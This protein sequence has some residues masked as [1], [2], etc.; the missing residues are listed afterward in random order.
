MKK[1]VFGLCLFLSITACNKSD[2]LPSLG[3]KDN[4]K[5]FNG[6]NKDL[7]NSFSKLFD[8]VENL[9]CVTLVDKKKDYSVVNINLDKNSEQT[10]EALIDK[11]FTN[12]NSVQKDI[13]FTEIYKNEQSPYR[14][15]VDSISDMSQYSEEYKLEMEYFIK[16]IENGEIENV[17]K[18]ISDFNNKIYTSKSLSN[19]EKVQLIA[20]SALTNSFY[21]FVKEGGLEKVQSSIMQEIYTSNNARIAGTCQVKW[22]DA[23]R[24]GVEGFFGGA[25]RGAWLGG[26]VGTVTVPGIGTVTGT[27]SGAVVL[28]AV[29]FLGGVGGTVAKQVVWDC[30]L[31]NSSD[32]IEARCQYYFDKIKNHEISF[33]HVPKSC[34]GEIKIEFTE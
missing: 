21:L 22:R 26:T 13:S 11:Y 27:V 9:N 5:D 3:S 1:I 15:G 17:P 2:D 7:T 25:I 16:N 18:I 19:D 28:G 8:S 30:I 29:G 32:A 6:L 4:E 20:F 33:Q 10:R 23:F 24:G 34:L 31:S 14:V 12:L